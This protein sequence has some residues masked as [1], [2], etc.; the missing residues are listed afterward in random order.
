MIETSVLRSPPDK[1]QKSN[2]KASR[3][4]SVREQIKKAIKESE[5]KYRSIFENAVWGIFQTTPEGKLI[6]ANPALAKMFGFKTPVEMV[7]HLK[8]I[9]NQVYVNPRQREKF[10][11]IL[12]N[13]GFVS[14]FESEVYHKSGKKFWISENA[15]VI[16]DG[17][18]GVLYYEGTVQ[19]VTERKRAEEERVQLLIEQSARAEAEEANRRFMFLVEA[20]KVL[21]QSLDYATTLK[22]VAGLAVSSLADYCVVDLFEEKGFKKLISITRYRRKTSFLVEKLLNF[23]P[24]KETSPQFKAIRSKRAILEP[25]INLNIL[26]Q[27]AVNDDHLKTL[28]ALNP[29]SLICI[30]LIAFDK[31]LGTITFCAINNSKVYS[32]S[33]LELAEELGRHAALAVNNSLLYKSAQEEI[34]MR[35]E[36]EDILRT[37]EKRFRQ[38]INKSSDVI[39]LIDER[40]RN[41]YISPSI[42]SVLG[43]KPV[44]FLGLSPFSILHPEDQK[45]TIEVIKKVSQVGGDTARGV[46][47]LRH[48]NGSWKWIEYVATNLLKD[49]DVGAIIVN[50]RDITERMQIQKHKDEFLAIASHELKTPVTTI[51]AFVQLL[52]RKLNQVGDKESLAYI[53][54]INNQLSSLTSLIKGLLDLTRIEEDRLLFHYEKI[55]MNELIRSIVEDIQPTIPHKIVIN[56]LPGEAK[57]EADRE[58]IGQVLTNL[59]T[60]SIKYSPGESMITISLK[61]KDGYLITSVKDFGMGI[62]KDMQKKIFERFFRAVTSKSDTYSGLGLGLYISREIVRRHKGE[63][64]L[65][66]VESKG[67]TFFFSLPKNRK[68]GKK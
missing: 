32:K 26:L 11:R 62:P 55:D 41:I 43:Y 49:P 66:S 8:N 7:R 58:R 52:D 54:R 36:I 14:D 42:K 45:K 39:T 23:T 6:T 46:Y 12:E 40:G 16:R 15:R 37:S 17:G 24:L 51:K 44:E 33:D 38:L 31:P 27:A 63:I 3:V 25:N 2:G 68:D 61:D 4:T 30:P 65:K 67:S 56:Y 28:K 60:N 13:R 50:F 59:L 19:D 9:E 47:R 35:F 18:G 34:T 64:W 20:S 48:K 5:R 10:I 53:Y 29:T 57:V 22:K 1:K 21:S